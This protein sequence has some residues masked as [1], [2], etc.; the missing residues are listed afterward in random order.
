VAGVSVVS[1]ESTVAQPTVATR[2]LAG[3]PSAIPE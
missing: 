3:L 2:C 1:G